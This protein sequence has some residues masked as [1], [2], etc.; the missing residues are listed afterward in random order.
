[1]GRMICHVRGNGGRRVPGNIGRRATGKPMQRLDDF[2]GIFWNE[3]RIS[4]LIRKVDAVTVA[5]GLACLPALADG[6]PKTSLLP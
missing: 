1:M 5:A 4:H 2:S 6:Q 3:E